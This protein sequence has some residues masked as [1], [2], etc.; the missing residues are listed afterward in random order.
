MSTLTCFHR[1]LTHLNV[2]L[3]KRVSRNTV[4]GMIANF[5]IWQGNQRIE[6]K[7]KDV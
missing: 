7:Q 1:M 6:E 3:K 4:Q 5:V 2:L